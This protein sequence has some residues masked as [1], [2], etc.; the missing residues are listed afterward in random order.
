MKSRLV[1][2]FNKFYNDFLF[3][4][5]WRLVFFFHSLFPVDKKLVVFVASCDKTMPKEYRLL[6]EKAEANGYKCVCLYDRRTKNAGYIRRQYEKMKYGAEFQRYYARAKTTFLYEYYLPAF[7]HKPRKGSRLVQLWHGCGA[8]KKFSYSTRDSKW[9]L[10]SK[11][12]D[13]YKVHK[14][15]T[16]IVASGGFIVPEYT[17][18]FNAGDGIIK[19]LGVPRTDVYFDSDF[20]KAQKDILL[21][22]YPRLSGKRLVLWAPTF[23]GNNMRSSYN[24]KAIDFVKLAASLDSD[25]VFLIKL[26]PFASSVLTFSEEEKEA[27]GE[28]ILNISDTVSTETALC[29]ADVVITDYSSLIFEYALLSR[30]MIF[31]AY[32]LDEYEKERGFYYDYRSFVPGKIAK[33]TDE[34]IDCIKNAEKDFD[35]KAVEA[36]KNKFMSAC[37]GHSTERIFQQL[38]AGNG[39][40]EAQV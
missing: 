29:C 17:E 9:G 27:I 39:G 13:R 38:I 14:S 21:K 23:R 2:A 31:Y 15:Y 22:T 20:V 19:V 32:D 36:F 37:D 18:A 35:K 33:N 34:L 24:D 7:S 16:D 4:V 5:V 10:E 11:L 8:F 40:K 25:T 30:P 26:H 3:F 12:F 6:Y 1:K 28:K